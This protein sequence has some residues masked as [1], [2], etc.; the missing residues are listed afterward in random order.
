MLFLRIDYT[1]RPASVCYNGQPQTSRIQILP[2]KKLMRLFLI[3]LL[4]PMLSQANSNDDINKIL[5]QQK[6][7]EGVVFEIVSGDPDFLKRAIPLVKQHISSLREKF[8]GLSIAVV[9]HG[10]EQFAL[11]KKNQGQ[12][13]QLH[14]EI[15]SLRQ[16]AD[17]PVHVCGAYASWKNVSPEEFPDYVDVSATGPAEIRQYQEFGFKKIMISD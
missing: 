16:D 2:M 1:S 15:V 13:R 10:D 14:N 9:T 8:P 11:T 6:P 5:Q 7:P 12:Y 3:F 17:V 4:L